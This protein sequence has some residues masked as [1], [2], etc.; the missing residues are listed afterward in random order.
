LRS[1]VHISDLHFG[2]TDPA[3]LPFL[4]RSIIAA[5]PDVVVVSGDLTQRAKIA[6]FRAA[7]EFLRELP[8]PQIV[9]PGN[10]DVPLYRIAS[11]WLTPLK[12]Y[13]HFITDD[14]EP[15]YADEEMAVIGL[16]TARS[17][18]FKEGRI[19]QKQVTSSCDR[20]Q[21]MPP[22][23]VRI[24]VTHHPFV[25]P[26]PEIPHGIVGRAEMAMTGFSDCKVDVVLSGHL[27]LSHV[28]SSVSQYGSSR[29]SALMVQAGTATSSRRRDEPNSFNILRI[30]RPRIMVEQMV[31]SDAAATFIAG[32]SQAFEESG[33]GWRL[34]GEHEHSHIAL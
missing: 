7:A 16:N 28:T 9:V 22:D 19:N 3:V 34:E 8:T 18:S 6:E 10:H 14:L 4:A 1:I 27:H 31:W 2:R 30:E 12:N 32:G 33:A 11:R 17:W 26:N 24:I 23:V 21:K 29:R 13:R 15:F 25:L 20:L 5:K